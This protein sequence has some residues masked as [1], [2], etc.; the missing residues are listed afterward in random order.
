[1]SVV[2]ET[3]DDEDELTNIDKFDAV[4][5]DSIQGDGDVFQGMR[6]ALRSLVVFQFPLLKNLHQ[7]N[8]SETENHFRFMWC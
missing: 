2:I 4:L 1:M 6:L 5:L 7:G 8:E 3:T